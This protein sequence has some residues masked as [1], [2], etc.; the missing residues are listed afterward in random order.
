[1][2]IYVKRDDA[3]ER[4]PAPLLEM[5]GKAEKTMTLVVTAEKKFANFTGERLLE[6]LEDKGFY[7]QLP[8]AMDEEVAAIVA[9]NNR[10]NH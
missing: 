4:V 5:F 8:P 7:L 2:Y 9:Q 1:M 3:M 10:L 6:V